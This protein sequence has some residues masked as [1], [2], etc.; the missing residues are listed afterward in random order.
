VTDAGLMHLRA[1]AGL[2]ELELEETQVSVAG[3][4]DLRRALPD[5]EIVE[6]VQGRTPP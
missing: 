5:V 6:S 3:V 2:R 1:L 4:E